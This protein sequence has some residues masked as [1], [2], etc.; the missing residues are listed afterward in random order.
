MAQKI[1]IYNIETI[2]TSFGHNITEFYDKHVL[3]TMVCIF[4]PE[5]GWN[6]AILHY[7]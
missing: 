5:F 3:L 7:I 2:S 1:L 6:H 4:C